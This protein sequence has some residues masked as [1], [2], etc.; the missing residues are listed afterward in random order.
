VRQRRLQQRVVRLAPLEHLHRIGQQLSL[1]EAHL[2]RARWSSA[3]WAGTDAGSGRQ[4]TMSARCFLPA[5]SHASAVSEKSRTASLRL[6][7]S[8]A[9]LPKTLAAIPG[10][11]SAR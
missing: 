3:G 1:A 8:S 10:L 6:V 7:H 2:G 11:P 5:S 9:A 4:R